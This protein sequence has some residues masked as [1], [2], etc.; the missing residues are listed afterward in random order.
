MSNKF[1]NLALLSLLPVFLAG[2]V[3][4]AGRNDDLRDW[5][6]EERRKAVPRVTPLKEPKPYMPQAYMYDG[7]TTEPYSS[8]RLTVALRR[9]SAIPSASAALIAPELVRRKEPLEAFPLDTMSM[10]GSLIRDGKRVALVKVDKLLYQVQDG[11]YLGQN[12]G[13]VTGIS[14]NQ[15]GL[16]EIVQDAAGEWIERHTELQLQESSK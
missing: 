3:G 8:E 13:R 16:R 7:R 14:E 2:V 5:M 4:C 15:V 6:G 9:D 10:V 11:N 1:K 12:Y